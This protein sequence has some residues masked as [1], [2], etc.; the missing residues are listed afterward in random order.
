MNKHLSIT[1]IWYL[2]I[3]ALVIFPIAVLGAQDAPRETIEFEEKVIEF[4]DFPDL[5][6][7]VSKPFIRYQKWDTGHTGDSWFSIALELT[8]NTDQFITAVNFRTKLY[9]NDG[10]LMSESTNATGPM[11]FE[12]QDGNVLKPG[13]RGVYDS[14]ITKANEFYSRF[15]RMELEITEVKTASKAVMDSPVFSGNLLSYEEYPGLE[16]QLSEPYRF[17]DDL[18]GEERFTIAMKFRNGTEKPVQ[19]INFFVRV[20]DNIGPLYELES[21]EHNRKYDPAPKNF[22]ATEFPAGYEGIN[23][24]FFTDDLSFFDVYTKIEIMLVSVD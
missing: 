5:I 10:T 24:S 6:I 20:F 7:R 8:N 18:S 3:I 15:G 23:M 9:A 21:Q 1:L 12:P 17:L 14:F 19:F 13:Y 16:F 4:E 22:F 11:T 2:Q